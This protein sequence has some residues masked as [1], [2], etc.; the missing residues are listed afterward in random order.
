MKKL[1][2]VLFI[3]LPA[4]F[5]AQQD[6]QYTLHQ[7]NT[8]L[9]NPAFTGSRGGMEANVSYRNQWMGMDKS[10]RTFGANFQKRYFGDKLATGV[11]YYGDRIGSLSRNVVQASQAYHLTMTKFNLSLALNVGLEQFTGGLAGIQHTISGEVDNAFAS[12]VQKTS[13]NFGAGAYLYSQ[14]FWAGFSFPHLMKSD[15]GKA[16]TGDVQA[17]YAS[18]HSFL[19]AGGIVNVNPMMDLKPYVLVKWTENVSPMMELGTMAFWM[20]KIGVGAGY[21]VGDA[22]I[23]NAEWLVSENFRIAYAY[24]RTISGLTA[25]SQGAHEIGIRYNMGGIFGLR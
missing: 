7:F 23:L 25:F 13:L 3:S 24:D 2:I 8:L 20:K 9:I 14:K 15:W 11:S 17:A 10:P 16:T 6:P 19:T 12:D 21:R 1:L 4:V 18:V 5:W 22:L